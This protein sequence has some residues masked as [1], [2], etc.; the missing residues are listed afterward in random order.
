[1]S[2]LRPIG[3]LSA[4]LIAL[5]AA[6]T[7]VLPPLVHSQGNPQPGTV[8]GTSDPT[9]PQADGLGAVQVAPVSAFQPWWAMTHMPAT[10]W[11]SPNPDATAFGE[12]PMW[13]WLQVLQP[14]EGNRFYIVNPRT[15]DYSYVDAGA[16]GAVGPPPDDYFEAPPPDDKALSL[17]ARIVGSPDTYD[18]PRRTDYFSL[19]RVAH[20]DR[21]TVQGEVDRGE[22]DRWYRIGD[23]EYVP[24]RSVRLPTPPDR[25][26]P[27]RWIDASLTE[28][29]MVTA[30]EGDQPVYSALA[31]KGATA[32]QTPRGVYRI[33]RRVENE[34]MD[35][36]TIGIPRT[37]PLGYYLKDVLYTQYFT[38]DGAA[39][40][41][42]YWRSDW[43]YG[44]SKGCLGMNLADSRFFWD[45]ASVGTVVYIHP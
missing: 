26:F 45:F 2:R 43:G 16:V 9:T 27:G 40:H 42:N 8:T 33:Q 25:T 31:V 30:Y 5:A 23:A 3:R 34:T 19:E 11:S 39:L 21:V 12:I 6:M 37:S 32:F 4:L 1:M 35:S 17:P 20:N 18:H 44:A 41:Y 7:L 24:A 36:A 14:A 38:G 22:D 13:R 28:P 10:A 29:A 15:G